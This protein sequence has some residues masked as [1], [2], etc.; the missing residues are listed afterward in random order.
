MSIRAMP[1][2]SVTDDVVLAVEVD[3]RG[4][5]EALA[6]FELLQPFDPFLVQ[7]AGD[8]WVVH[9]SAPG[10]RGEPLTQALR[11]VDQWCAERHQDPGVRVDGQQQGG[12]TTKRSRRRDSNP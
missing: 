2:P 7:H 11:T 5:W 9:A 10:R 6:L 3:V 8:H 1:A 4:R 12:M